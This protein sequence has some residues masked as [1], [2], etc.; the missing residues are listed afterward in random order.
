MMPLDA[1]TQQLVTFVRRMP[2]DALL[3]LVRRQLRGDGRNAAAA[4]PAIRPTAAKALAG[5]APK[6][7]KRKP[8]VSSA[9]AKKP[10]AAPA[11]VK[12]RATRAEREQIRGTVEQAIKASNGLGL[13]EIAKTTGVSKPRVKAALLELRAA[14]RIYQAG[15]R[16]FA[17]YAG[18]AKAAKEAAKAAQ[19]R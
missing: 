12:T 11:G 7:A 9:P 18:T 2:D 15:D 3:E 1:F 8:A 5:G 14:K 6:P 16:K 13:G 4:A 17:R 19:G 10:A